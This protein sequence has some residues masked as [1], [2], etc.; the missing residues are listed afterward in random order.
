[1]QQAR[2]NGTRGAKAAGAHRDPGAVGGA[3]VE[4][5]A[6]LCDERVLL[7]ERLAQ[8]GQLVRQRL[9]AR[10]QCRALLPQAKQLRAYSTVR[11]G[12]EQFQI[13]QD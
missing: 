8:R 13:F 12:F 1:M 6:Q 4:L 5:D 9:D 2:A 7:A 3:V 11:A 10:L